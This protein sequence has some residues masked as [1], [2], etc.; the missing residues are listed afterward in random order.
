M[1]N[2]LF[3]ITLNLFRFQRMSYYFTL[4]VSPLQHSKNAERRY[5]ALR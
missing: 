3:F 2:P 4:G 5:L 1:R